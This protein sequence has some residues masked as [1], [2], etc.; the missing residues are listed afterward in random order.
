MGSLYLARD[1]VLDRLVAI[2]LL[3]DDYRD[4]HEL[5][6][7]F[8][9]E[10]RSVARLRHPNIIVVF[11][12]GEDDGRPFIAMEYIAGETLGAALRQTPPL[13]LARRLLLIEQLCAGLAHAHAAGIVHRD[14]KPDN[15]M[16]DGEVLKILDFGIARLVNSGMTQNGMMLG[17][18]NYMSPEQIIGGDI[19]A[20]TDI[21]AAGAVLYEVVALQRAFPGGMDTGVLNKILNEGPTPLAARVPGVDPEL[22]AVVQRALEREPARR[23]QD[24]NDLGRELARAR[25]RLMGADI[26][27]T[28]PT[29]AGDTVVAR[30]TP[31]PS[32]A[33]PRSDSGSRRR[34]DPERAA[35]LRR[36]Q[37]DE[38]LRRG[39]EALASGDYESAIQHAERAAA[40]DPDHRDAFD[41]ID[42]ARFQLDARIIRQLVSEAE[43]LC[44]EGRLDEAASVARQAST[45]ASELPDVELRAEVKRICDAVAEERS[46]AERIDSSLRRARTSIE[47]GGYET[48][49]RAVYEVLALDPE[50][51]DAR[52]LEQVAKERLRSQRDQEQAQRLALERLTQARTLAG[53]GRFED[54]LALI[55]GVMPASET[56]RRA[57]ADALAAVRGLRQQADYAACFA[58]AQTAFDEGHIDQAVAALDGVPAGDL[59]PAMRQLL[60]AADDVLR[61]RREAEQKSRA[62]EEALP[63]IDLL[64]DRGDLAGARERLQAAMRIGLHDDRL[65]T[66]QHRIAELEAAAGEKRRQEIRDR[67]AAKNIDRA[68]QRLDA[69]DVPGAL[70]LLEGDTSGHPS[71]ESM[72]GDVRREVA[73]YQDRARQQAEARRAD[74]EARREAAAEAARL[75]EQDDARRAAALK[76]ERELQ[77][78]RAE[79]QRRQEETRLRE[80]DERVGLARAQLAKG[81]LV[82]ARDIA[83]ATLLI[84]AAHQDTLR[85]RRQI[86]EAI[87][88]RDED[89][90]RQQDADQ[91]A[92]QRNADAAG[93]RERR[94]DEAR[95][96]PWKEPPQ[97][98]QSPVAPAMW[99]SAA[100]TIIAVAVVAGVLWSSAPTTTVPSASPITPTGPLVE[101]PKPV[102]SPPPAVPIGTLQVDAVPW[103]NVTI[104]P[105][106]GGGEA[107]QATLVTPA[108]LQLPEGDYELRFENPEFGTRT[109]TK[110]KVT[111]AQPTLV[112]ITLPGFD[113]ERA[114]DT[115]LGER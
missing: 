113:P 80:I 8:A 111:S 75:R 52:E 87:E 115:I 43:R 26:E 73:A 32:S 16:L 27:S 110:A 1:P 34:L 33:A 39:G 59:T 4:D 74:E 22:A 85:V 36:Q 13:P 30:P 54:A 76:A 71:I 94:T 107:V 51:S 9:R 104:K 68:R 100:A 6:E 17:S 38:H 58:A 56:V 23:Y 55:E 3:R 40:V 102:A 28:T 50:R 98:S 63:S 7:R 57:A 47:Q 96:G 31:S 99:F 61:A 90:R 41:L 64:V 78:Q 112:R 105:L 108:S 5:R 49:L 109:I 18:V 62:L 91:E 14:I 53:Q 65:V 35:E 20:R 37:L 77:E 67:L 82:A 106:T 101:P 97:T 89:A 95:Q 25:R 21:F 93:A 86:D 44:A 79:A 48:A 10:A 88:R 11:D 42:K 60:Q 2:K 72:L 114:V 69:G 29:A 24:A 66:R 81:D 103:A 45:A 12:V 19:D 46:R 84:D 15:M 92:I 83:D 70:A